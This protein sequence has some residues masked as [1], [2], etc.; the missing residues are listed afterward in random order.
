MSTHYSSI[1]LA[2][3]ARHR[4]LDKSHPLFLHHFFSQDAW[5][6]EEW[7]HGCVAGGSSAG[8]SQSADYYRS[9]VSIVLG[10]QCTA[11]F[12][13]GKHATV[14]V[15]VRREGVPMELAVACG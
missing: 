6:L 8:R 7:L 9:H 15:A 1:G 11:C 5:D 13:Q 14:D 10:G 2:H 12:G 3:A 4:R